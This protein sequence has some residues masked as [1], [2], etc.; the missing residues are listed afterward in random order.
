MRGQSAVAVAGRYH[1]LNLATRSPGVEFL[2]RVVQGLYCERGP[3]YAV[4][5]FAG[6]QLTEQIIFFLSG[7][8]GIWLSYIIGNESRDA[9]GNEPDC[10]RAT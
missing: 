6:L 3:S 9:Y 7:N 8:M 10:M 2:V 5:F 4:R 1:K